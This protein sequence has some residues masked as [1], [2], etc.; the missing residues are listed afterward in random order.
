MNLIK[1]TTVQPKLPILVQKKFTVENIIKQT[2]H[3]NYCSVASLVPATP[4]PN[5]CY[6]IFP[7]SLFSTMDFFLFL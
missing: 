5:V 2:K 4:L 7:L 1:Y 6:F 3:E